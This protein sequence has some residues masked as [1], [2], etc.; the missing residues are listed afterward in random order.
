MREKIVFPTLPKSVK[1]LNKAIHLQPKPLLV[2][3]WSISCNRCQ[4]QLR[5]LQRE[6]QQ[7]TGAWQIVT[8]HMPRSVEDGDEQRIRAA[9]P[10]QLPII[11]DETLYFSDA[12]RVKFVPAI[13][14]FDEARQLKFAQQGTING[15]LVRER[16]QKIVNS[17]L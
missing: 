1:V 6:L 11:V 9:M 2:Y 3:V 12:L 16:L 15:R 7:V 14:I 5:L 17:S 10:E 8:I 4:A 13:Y